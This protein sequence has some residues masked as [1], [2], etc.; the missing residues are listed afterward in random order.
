MILRVFKQLDVEAWLNYASRYKSSSKGGR[1][2][3]AIKA[4]VEVYSFYIDK[5]TTQDEAKRSDGER[6]LH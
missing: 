3:Y 1:Y 2:S 4:Q 5:E 6:G